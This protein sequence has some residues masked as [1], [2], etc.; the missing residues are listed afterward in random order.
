MVPRIQTMKMHQDTGAAPKPQQQMIPQTT[1]IS[2]IKLP[3]LKK[4]EY[5]IWA[6]EMEHY[7]EYIDNE[8][9]KVIQNGNS[10]K[11]ISTGKD[12]VVRVLSPVSAAEIQAVEK[13]RKAKNILLMAIPKEHMRR[14][15]WNDDAKEIWEAIRTRFGGLEK[16]YDRFQQ[17]LSQFD[18]HGAEEVFEQEIQGAPKPSLSAQNVAFVSQSKK[19][20]WFCLMK[21]IES[22]FAKQTEDLD[23]LH[24]V[25]NKI[26]DVEGSVRVDGKTPVGFDKISFE[27]FKF[28]TT[29]VSLPENGQ[30]KG[31]YDGKKKRD[32][33]YQH[34][35]AGKQ[36]KNQMGLLTMDDGIVNWG[37]H[38]EAEESNHAL[39]AISS[40]N[41][42]S[43]CS[44][45]C[46]DS[47]NKLKTLFDE[48]MNQL[49]DQ[50][51]QIL[52]YSLAVKK[53]E[54][55]LLKRYRRIGMKAV[56]EKEQ[57]QK[58]VDSWNNSSKN[59]WRLINS[60][61]SS[62]DKLGLGFEIQSNDEVLSYEEEMNFS[63]FKCSKEDS[64]GKPSYSRFT[65]TNDFKGVPPPLSGDYTPQPQEEID[66]ALYVYGKKGPQKPEISVS[67]E[68]SSEH[69][70][71][72]SNDSEGSCENTSEHSFETES[73]SVSEPSEM[74]KSRQPLKD[75][76]THKVNR[77]SW[78][79][80]MK[81]E[82]GDGYS[83]TKKKCFVCGSLN[84]LI[85][86]CDYYEKKMAREAEE[87]RVVNTGNGVTKPV[88]T[89]ANRINHSN[90][91]VPRSV[92]LNAGRPKFNSVRPNISTGRTN[93]N[94]GRTNISSGRPKVNTVSPKVNS[95]RPTSNSMSPK[96]P[97][98]DQ[99]NKRRDFSKS[100]S[101]V[102][103][104]FS[105]STAQMAHTNAVMGS[106]GFA[107]KTSASYNWR[108]SRP[109]FNYNSGP[110]FIRT[111]HPLKNM[112]DRGIFDSG[113]SGHM[114]GNKDQLEDF[115]EFNGGSV[116]FG[117]SKGYISG[118]GRIRVGNLD[119]DSVS[120]V[121][122]LGHF[123]L[124]SISQI[125]DKQ[126]KVLFTETECLVVSSDFKMPDENQI[127]LKVPRHHNMYSFDMKTP[128]PA[129][130][131][132]C[133]IAKATSDESKLWHRRLGH[134][135]FKNLNKLV[136]GNLVRGLP[137]KVFKN[138]HTCVACHK[139]KQ[140]RAS[141]KA[142]LERLITKP[143]HTLHMDLFGPTS[144]KSI[145]HASYCL[146][147]TDD[148]TRFCWVFFLASKDE[149][150]GIL[151]TFIRQIENQLSHKVKIIRSDNGTEFKNRDMLEFCGNKGIKQEY[152][153]ARTP[154]QNGVAERMN[155]T[156]IEAA[157]TMLADSLLPTTFWAEAVSTACYI[158]NRILL[159]VLGKFDMKIWMWD[160]SGYSLNSKA[161]RVY[162]LVT[163][164]VEVNL[165]V[166]FLEEKPNVKGVGYRWMFDIDYLTDSM[167]YIP[168]S[169]ENQANN[170]GI[171]EETN[172]AGT[173][174]PESIASEEK[175][176]EVEL[177]V[178]PSAVKIPEEKDESRTTSTNSKTEETLTEPQ[179]EM[180]DS[181]IDSLEDNPKIQAF[182]RELEEIALKHLG[183]VPENNTTSTHSVNTGRLDHDDSLMPELEIFHKPETGIFDEAS[184]DEEGVITD[185]NSLPTE[186]EVSPT[187]TLRIHSIHPK[188][189]I[190]GDP[191]SAVQTRSKVQNKSGAHALLS[192][193]QKQ[194][195][196]N[197]KD[198]QHCLFA[199]FLSQEEPK[200]IAEALQDDSW[201]QAMQEELLQFKLQQVWV[202]VDIPHGMMVIG[203]RLV[204]QG[205]TQE[206]GIDYDEVFAP[207]ARI[208]A[209]RHIVKRFL[210]NQPPGFVD[211][212]HPTK[213]YKVVKALYGLHQAPRAWYATLSTFLEKHGYKRGTIDKTLFIKRDKKD[214]ML[215]QVYVDDIIFGST[216][217]S[218]CAEFEALM[219]SRFQMSSMGELTFFLG[220]QVKQN[221]G[222][223]FIS[224]DKYVAEILKKFDLV[225][226]KAAITPM[227]TKL[228]LTKDEEA[229]DVD[230]HLYRSMIGYSKIFSS[231]C[232]Q[233]ESFKVS[234]KGKTQ[235][236]G[237]WYPRESPFDLEAFSDSD[238][239]G[240]N[241]DRK[242]TTGGCQFLGQRLIS[243]QC[244]KQTIVATSYIL[245]LNMLAA[246]KLL[247]DNIYNF[248]RITTQVSQ[249]DCHMAQLKYCDKHN[250]VGFLRKPD[251][252]TGF[253][254]IV[255]FLRGSNLRYALTTN[256]TIYDS[257]VKQFWQSATANTKTDGS[258][259]INATIDTIRYT[260]SEASIR[261]SLQ[262]EDATG[263]TMLPNEEL[264]EGMGQIGYPTDGTF[265]FW[266]SFFTPQWRYLVHHLLHCISSKSGGWDQFGS[267]I[268]TAL[269]CLS[270]GRV[271]NF[272]K[273]IFDGMVANLKSKTKFLMYPRFLQMILNVQTEDKHLYL[274][275]SL[276]KKIFGNMK[277]GF[278]GAPRPLLPSMLLV[279]TNPNAGQEHAAVAQS[280]PS[281]STPQV[282]TPPPIP[283]SIPPPIP[284]PTP[285]PISTPI[286]P[287]IPTP[288][289]P[290]IPTP[291]PPPI[292]TPIPPP[293]PTPTPPP[294]PSPTQIPDTE[295]TPFEHT[296]EESSPIHQHFSPSQ[297]QA[298][299]QMPMD[300]LLHEVPKLIS[301]ID[302]LEMDLKQTKLTMGNAIV[303][304][305][306]KVKKLEE[307]VKRRNL[308]LS[309]SEEEEPEVQGRKSS[310][311]EQ[312][313]DIS[314]NTLEA[315]KTLS[316]VASLKP[317]SID[318]GRRYKRRKEAKG[319]LVS[320][321]DF[322]EEVD[323]G[324]EQVN[325]AEGVNTGSIKLSTVS[326]Q[327]STGSE[328]VSTVGTKESTSSQDKGQREGKAPMLSEETPKK[329]DSLQ[330]EEEA[331]QIHLDSLL[332]QRIAEEEELNEKQKK[333]KAQVQFEAQHY[334]NEDWDLIRA[335]I[336]AN[337][338]KKYFAEERARAKRNK[339]MTQ[340]QL[341]TYMMNHL[342]NQGIWKLSQLKKLSLKEVKEEFDKLVKQVESF[343]PINFEATKASLK[344]FG[345][346]LQTK[347]QKRMKDDE[348][349]DD[350]PTKKS[351]KRRKQM[352]RK[353]LHIDL[354]EDDSEG[355][356]DVDKQEE[357]VTGTKTPT[358]IN[359]VPVAM[360]TPSIATYKIIKQGE[361]GVYQIVREDGTDIVYINF[362]AMLKSI[363]RDDLTELY[364]IVMN[365]YWDYGPR[366]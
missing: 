364:R 27:C 149:T 98:M 252:S 243:W 357:S 130:G 295:P 116:T 106:W 24:V 225:N 318:K 131:F 283:T 77:K 155:R 176:E 162:N 258:L 233:R 326:E 289:P 247:W 323:T 218:W 235:K 59:L 246:E 173:H 172:S 141:C 327:L 309:D 257:L 264:F 179:Q 208:E 336:E 159:S 268:A 108:N 61:M 11:R 82:L 215:V 129:K 274:A 285:P 228:P 18:D 67:D 30:T 119:F 81:R 317:R 300:D 230:V 183:K 137:S 284:T 28:V 291:I 45:T 281:S 209:I 350:E 17:L 332:A 125:C 41:E 314:P 184:Y 91:F 304:L 13:E 38:T 286:P 33:L 20:C 114:T 46:I 249:Y 358:P 189:Q 340:S 293:I 68:N 338:E 347:T 240:S 70:T 23:L 112:V 211:P 313:E 111:E 275:V 118:K 84:H 134:I 231:Q 79:D 1:A 9:W 4:E 197:H 127:L 87:K 226:V 260:I 344:R 154:Q 296:Y 75:N 132:A 22:L 123:N 330:K 366:V 256:P 229:F 2:N 254:E 363:T 331:K 194:Q 186:I 140:H 207:V 198:Q 94:T 203:T 239:G 220:L 269:I 299:S 265:T 19:F 26:D 302:S 181:S 205:Y 185:F 292:P 72:Q 261:D 280:Q 348:A 232:C 51:A 263:I 206:E 139:G 16:G 210:S 353:R 245:K 163:K 200:K 345:K 63:V 113:C 144:V 224:Q 335:K 143:L 248:S 147:I 204:A 170:A 195:R 241:L 5:D 120:F 199:C 190:L 259:E 160:L 88:W 122:E 167:N 117:G 355:P 320:Q 55:Q 223:I 303:K 310:R 50:E 333:R 145:N 136:K 161:Y 142:K 12:G 44:K 109:N 3:I 192:H 57:L 273:L 270:T 187:P 43:L 354:D 306:K 339:P 227:E 40:S 351:G 60:G 151:Q 39:M 105:K 146:V 157:R 196:N 48:Q 102:R 74:S 25:W 168:V 356:D 315:A 272:S 169:L 213:V 78:N 54:A 128:S 276:T 34:Q 95:V 104:P 15:S 266:K 288:I 201:V 277:R 71:C 175:D 278:R 103:R 328:Q 342:K 83:F 219:K 164:R 255:D 150:S 165:H 329:L 85:K 66:D 62:N 324:A 251:E 262:L 337:A 182:R 80:M 37:E 365:R 234:S 334:T 93:I 341:K 290:P 115:E 307:F 6:M 253:A 349:K 311:E 202:L 308:V 152:S 42:V 156:L 64:I 73:A 101:S 90:N 31:T 133:L 29:L 346:E 319:K 36:E 96:R 362:G 10:K 343:A 148:C 188:S 217:K 271:Y 177:I 214:I 301:R 124:F 97:Q 212:D 191:K 153:N 325:T 237:F 35:E 279:A 267:N 53:L 250:Q 298:P 180:K 135:N 56:K 178:V 47:Y 216:N 221:K 171:S 222:G 21:V 297:E 174:R 359:P 52:A 193:T 76:E 294:I 69:S 8:V 65:K 99:I 89:N 110:T 322:Q 238:Y 58:T 7:L 158:F 236:L 244:K 121:K 242:S 49:G 282:P 360:K 14:F 138:D 100:Y 352:A 126:H 107:V 287:P 32:S 316:K 166:N 321:L 86:D 312:V 361:K 92:Q 305:V